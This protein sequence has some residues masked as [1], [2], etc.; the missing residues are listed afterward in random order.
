MIVFKL[1]GKHIKLLFQSQK[2]LSKWR[3][4]F[5]KNGKP[6]FVKKLKI[7][8]SLDH[9][10]FFKFHQHVVQKPIEIIMCEEPLDYQCQHHQW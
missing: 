5:V 2:R 9:T 3:Q 6:F 8:Y 1:I 7:L 4:H 10:I